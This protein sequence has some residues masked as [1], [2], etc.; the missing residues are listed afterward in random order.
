MV[1]E[2]RRQGT[3]LCGRAGSTRSL[4]VH[5]GADG[6]RLVVVKVHGVF[7][8]THSVPRGVKSGP[9]NVLVSV[10]DL[11][12]GRV[13]ENTYSTG[14]LTAGISPGSTDTRVDYDLRGLGSP[15]PLALQ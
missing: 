6:D 2:C 12:T 7:A 11:A 10:L 1:H 8:T 15:V 13:V 14:P 3:D 5:A 4:E 9:V